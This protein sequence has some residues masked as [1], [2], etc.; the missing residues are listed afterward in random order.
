MAYRKLKKECQKVC[1]DSYNSYLSS[2]LDDSTK[3]AK[4]FWTFVKGKKKDQIGITALEH[5]GKVYTD[6]LSKA[7]LLNNQFASVFTREDLAVT[8]SKNEWQ[9]GT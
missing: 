5:Q 8:N 7:S 9:P 4:K 2:L 3:C 6:S 1:H